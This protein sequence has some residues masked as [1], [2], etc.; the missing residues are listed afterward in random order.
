[1]HI[2]GALFLGLAIA[3]LGAIV[4][5]VFGAGWWALAVAVAILAVAP[6]LILASVSRGE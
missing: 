2:A 3:A 4:A 6:I 5:L 1:M